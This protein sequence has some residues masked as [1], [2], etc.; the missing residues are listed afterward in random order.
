[1]SYLVSRT[2]R[3]VHNVALAAG[4]EMVVDFQDDVSAVEVVSMDGVAPVFFTVD[5]TAAAVNGRNCH[6]I[7]AVVSSVEVEPTSSGPTKVRLISAAAQT[8]SVSRA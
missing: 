6:V 5:G 2:E 8:V 4:V 1:M 3:G 7:P